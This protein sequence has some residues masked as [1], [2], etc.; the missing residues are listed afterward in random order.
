MV[1]KNNVFMEEI[2]VVTYSTVW[3]GPYHWGGYSTVRP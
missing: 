3:L 2:M 1:N